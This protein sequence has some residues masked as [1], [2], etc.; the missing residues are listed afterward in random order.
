[1][2]VIIQ[3]MYSD[4]PGRRNV[5]TSYQLF[6]RPKDRRQIVV[7]LMIAI[8]LVMIVSRA[9]AAP[10]TT[11]VSPEA[12]A[13]SRASA[14]GDDFD[15]SMDALRELSTAGS[16]A[17]PIL[18]DVARQ[19][20]IRDAATIESETPAIVAQLPKLRTDEADYQT[21]RTQALAAIENLTL[22]AE[23]LKEAHRNFARLS[24]L[25]SKV[26]LI[27]ARQMHVIEALSRREQCAAIVPSA[28]PAAE[29]EKLDKDAAGALAISPDVARKFLNGPLEPPADPAA[30]Q[31][32]LY[33]AS[34]R[35]EKWNRQVD[36]AMSA[37]ETT[38]LRRVNYYREL[39]GFLLFEADARLVQSARRHSKEMIEL[40]YFS[41]YSPVESERSPFTRMANA[42]YRDGS[43]EN[44][45]L[46]SWTAEDAFQQFFNSPEHHRAWLSRDDTTMGVG[47]WENA[48]TEDI[49]AGPRLMT[50][51]DAD[52]AANMIR[53]PELKPQLTET[54]RQHPRD[55]ATIKFYDE[56][57]HE[58]KQV[59][60]L[61]QKVSTSQQ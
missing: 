25:H 31:L 16:A 22:D 14:L 4:R 40:W 41:H 6:A 11:P 58:V 39:L 43:N 47:K 18:N 52:R 9:Q 51:S 10:T 12:I 19:L 13:L 57:G 30:R 15:K 5:P 35:I 46:G 55:L 2:N 34:R 54:T 21:L 49:G 23:S 56:S 59:L 17:K 26:A 38:H 32:W 48:W 60:I 20:L 36:P 29:A 24:N 53:G 44:I 42:G 8:L 33:V 45:T 27:Y 7:E 50:A 1:M 61:K 37:A 3:R 28:I